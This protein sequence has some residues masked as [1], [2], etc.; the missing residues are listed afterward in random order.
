MVA[1]KKWPSRIRVE[2]KSLQLLRNCRSL[3]ETS[4]ATTEGMKVFPRGSAKPNRINLNVRGLTLSLYAFA[5]LRATI[6]TAHGNAPADR[7]RLWQQ[8]ES[9][10]LSACW[11]CS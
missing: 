3:A 6:L 7:E 2:A 9:K 1:T 8:P 4:L 11:L 5:P 10:G